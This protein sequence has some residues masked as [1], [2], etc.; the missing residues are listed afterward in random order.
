MV[1][2]EPGILDIYIIKGKY[3]LSGDYAFLLKFPTK[4]KFKNVFPL[5]LTIYG[6]KEGT[7]KIMHFAGTRHFFSP[8]SMILFLTLLYHTNHL[9]F[10]QT[11]FTDYQW[12]EK[13]QLSFQ[14]IFGQNRLGTDMTEVTNL[15]IPAR[16]MD[17]SGKLFIHN[18]NFKG[19]YELGSFLLQLC[20]DY[21]KIEGA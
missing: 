1:F 15:G 9:F 14:W 8:D 20:Y 16:I 13:R 3:I 11:F 2:S 5:V 12:D 17:T 4:T 10:Y 19:T 18:Q 6:T 21:F 7:G